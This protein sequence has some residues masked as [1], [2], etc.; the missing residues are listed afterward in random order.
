MHEWKCDKL[1]L[2][3]EDKNIL[4]IFQE[5]FG[6]YLLTFDKPFKDYI[7]GKTENNIVTE[8]ENG[9][10]LSGKE[11]LIEMM[12]LTKCNSLIASGGSGSNGVMFFAEKNFDNIYEFR[13]GSYG[14]YPKY[15]P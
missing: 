4:Q 1:F 15:K 13:L 10:F 5:S 9:Y 7:V 14:I 11:Y 3:T 2:A 12:L 6:D 8:R